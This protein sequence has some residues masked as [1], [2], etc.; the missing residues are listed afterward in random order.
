MKLDSREIFEIVKVYQ[1]EVF[2][3]RITVYFYFPRKS[4]GFSLKRG[5]FSLTFSRSAKKLSAITIAF[6]NSVY[7]M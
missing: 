2:E 1:I 6:Y 4:M 3:N 5:Q 7:S